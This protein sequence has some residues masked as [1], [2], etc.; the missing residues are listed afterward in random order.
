[1]FD[2]TGCHGA[3]MYLTDLTFIEDGTPDELTGGLINFVKRRK[4]AQVLCPLPDLSV[5]AA[6]TL[7]VR[8][9]QVIREIQQYQQCPYNFETVP[10][11]QKLIDTTRVLPD[12]EAYRRSLGEL[13]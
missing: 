8:H 11:I 4:V 2:L 1:M 10:V 3:G 5:T 7:W 9:P 12:E 6:L 13:G